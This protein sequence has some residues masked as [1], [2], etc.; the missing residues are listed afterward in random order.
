[1]AEQG[2]YSPDWAGEDNDESGYVDEAGGVIRCAITPYS[3]RLAG[4]AFLT[5]SA[6]PPDQFHSFVHIIIFET[7]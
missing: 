3:L 7:K 1:L 6:N 2:I 5:P 4:L